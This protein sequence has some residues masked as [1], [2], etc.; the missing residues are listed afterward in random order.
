V[1]QLQE[2]L[3]FESEIG[4]WRL[5]FWK[6]VRSRRTH[7]T[8]GQAI[9]FSDEVIAAAMGTTAEAVRAR[10]KELGI[11]PLLP[12]RYLRRRI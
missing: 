8:S 11:H 9:W 7:A 4:D 2:M 12:G 5:G 1:A 10:R 3:R 6:P